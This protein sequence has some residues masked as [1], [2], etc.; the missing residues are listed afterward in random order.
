MAQEQDMEVN[1]QSNCLKLQQTKELLK[2]NYDA[3]LCLYLI[4][5]ELIF[6]N[7]HNKILMQKFC[8]LFK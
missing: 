1:S 8:F 3:G 7:I 2:R 5:L 6:Q 4:I